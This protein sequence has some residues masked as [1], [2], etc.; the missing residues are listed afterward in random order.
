MHVDALNA[1]QH[2]HGHLVFMLYLFFQKY[3]IRNLH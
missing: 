2:R 1:I 3:E